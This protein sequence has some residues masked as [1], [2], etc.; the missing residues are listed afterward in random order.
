MDL[1]DK[2]TVVDIPKANLIPVQRALRDDEPD[3]P[4]HIRQRPCQDVTS[5]VR[6]EWDPVRPYEEL[7]GVLVR[8]TAMKL[9]GTAYVLDIRSDEEE[10]NAPD[11][12]P[13]LVLLKKSGRILDSCMGN[14]QVGERVYI[15]YL[16]E[17]TAKPGMH[18]ARDW[19][20][21]KLL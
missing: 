8:R 6:H 20:V 18:P 7:E 10:T 5:Q 2:R 21:I 14:V 4:D 9:G 11:S 15:R 19:R 3:L 12:E 1:K 16:G 17:L 13:V